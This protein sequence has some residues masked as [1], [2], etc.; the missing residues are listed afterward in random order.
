MDWPLWL[1]AG[2]VIGAGAGAGVAAALARGRLRRSLARTREAV[3]EA[4][5]RAQSAERFAE[6]GAM[7]SGGRQTPTTAKAMAP[8]SCTLFWLSA[9]QT[10][11][12]EPSVKAKA[13]AAAPMMAL[14][15][16]PSAMICWTVLSLYFID[17]PR[18]PLSRLPT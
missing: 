15:G 13:I 4:E 1:I 3:R 12:R 2:I 18:S 6:I 14:V 7:T 16:K 11:R 17:G 5:K 10:P 9:A 8:I